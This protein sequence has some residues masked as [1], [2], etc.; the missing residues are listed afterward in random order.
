MKLTETQHKIV[1]LVSG[2]NIRTLRM[3]R[4]QS[5][6]KVAGI[7]GISP[8]YL[9]RIERAGEKTQVSTLLALKLIAYE[10]GREW[11]TKSY[12]ELIKGSICH[13]R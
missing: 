8:T 11:T 9:S 6:R 3:E 1:H 2:W 12:E 5:L 10:E 13:K 4:E 7:L